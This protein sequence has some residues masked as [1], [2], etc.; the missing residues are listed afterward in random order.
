MKVFR[1]AFDTCEFQEKI[2]IVVAESAEKAK[3]IVKME[4]LNLFNFSKIENRTRDIYVN[5]IST[6]EEGIKDTFYF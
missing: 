6:N 3:E 1:V 5:E 4:N 2:C